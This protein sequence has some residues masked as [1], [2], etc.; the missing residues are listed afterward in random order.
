MSEETDAAAPRL[1]DYAA[2]HG[3]AYY[4]NWTLPE[5][6]Q[7]MRHGFMREA[8][9]VLIGDLPCGLEDAWLAHAGYSAQ[10]SRGRIEERIFTM[11]V[12]RA[13]ASIRYAV[14]VL[15]HDRDLSERDTSNP[16]A[17]TEV[18]ELDDTAVELES[19]EFLRRYRLS[20]DHDQDQLR[21]WQLFSPGLIRWLTDS[22]PRDFSCLLY[23]SP[24]PRDS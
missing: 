14:R 13:P 8:P 21:V 23:T 22:A 19:V 2:A 24:S 7:L 11:V 20:T 3:L 10:T 1:K 18:V 4:P 9:N 16:D 15:C 6:T 12:A 17:D 5:A